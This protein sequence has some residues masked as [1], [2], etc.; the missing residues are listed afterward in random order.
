M[1]AH[2]YGIT[3]EQI[4]A[5]R[6]YIFHH[7]DEVLTQHLALEARNAVGNPPEAIETMKA[8]RE[9]LLRYREWMDQ[10][11]A[12]ARVRSQS[13]DSGTSALPPDFPTFHEWH[14]ESVAN[15]AGTR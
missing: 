13:P 11:D 2:L 5:A 8:S 7:L 9:L 4:A 14:A 10:R 3:A 6:A 1:I 15:A 12:E